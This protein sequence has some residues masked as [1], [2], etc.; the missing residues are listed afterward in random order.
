MFGRITEV[1][2][3]R[4]AGSLKNLDLFQDFQVSLSRNSTQT[5]EAQAQRADRRERSTGNRERR[6]GFPRGPRFMEGRRAGHWP[7][8][9]N[10]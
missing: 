6:W 5:G 4:F 3:A 2:R 10:G 9:A 8:S 1:H 7:M